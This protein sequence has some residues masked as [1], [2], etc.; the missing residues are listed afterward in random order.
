MAIK[1]LLDFFYRRDPSFLAKSNVE[2]TKSKTEANLT[3]N[4]ADKNAKS[5]D[6][7]EVGKKSTKARRHIFLIRHGQYQIT[8]REKD[9]Q[10]LTSLGIN[11]NNNNNINISLKLFYIII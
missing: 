2:L 1:E 7:M 5:Q 9:K 8:N 11:N 10:V 6:D 4:V 3:S